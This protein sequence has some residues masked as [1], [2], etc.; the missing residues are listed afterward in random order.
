LGAVEPDGADPDCADGCESFCA[1]A[2]C[3]PFREGITNPHT[4]RRQRTQSERFKTELQKQEEFWGR[5][6][7]VRD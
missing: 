1:K 3:C 4:R 7:E 2:A 6:F 5:A